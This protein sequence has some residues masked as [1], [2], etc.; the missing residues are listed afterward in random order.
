MYFINSNLQNK[1]NRGLIFKRRDQWDWY[2]ITKRIKE[3]HQA[4]LG[5]IHGIGL[6][7]KNISKLILSIR[8]KC[9]KRYQ[10]N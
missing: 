9:T 5:K 10:S 8:L 6:R 7:I 2:L 1:V 4:F 3:I